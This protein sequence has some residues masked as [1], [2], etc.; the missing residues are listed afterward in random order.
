MFTLA[1]NI[2]WH[3]GESLVRRYELPTAQ[4]FSKCFCS[5]CGSPVPSLSRDGQRLLIPAGSL[6]ADPAMRPQ[7]RIYYADR[8]AWYLNVETVECFDGAPPA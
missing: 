1:G 4:R 2:R 7:M 8:A 5:V 3:A 6:D